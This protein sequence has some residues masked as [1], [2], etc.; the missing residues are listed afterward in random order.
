MRRDVDG[1]G[2][3]ARREPDVVGDG[4]R[5]G[6]GHRTTSLP[7]GAAMVHVTRPLPDAIWTTSRSKGRS[8]RENP[9]ACRPTDRSQARRA[10]GREE[11]AERRRGRSR[12][13][14]DPR[15]DAAGRWSSAPVAA[16]PPRTYCSPAIAWSSDGTPMNGMVQAR[17]GTRCTPR[18]RMAKPRCAERDRDAP[19]KPVGAARPGSREAAA[20]RVTW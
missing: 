1:R 5:R 16:M 8:L 18:G 4:A 2:D 11:A 17:Q 6:P 14:S 7:P 12:S 9:R 20:P 3:R 19:R 13:W 10:S 15:D